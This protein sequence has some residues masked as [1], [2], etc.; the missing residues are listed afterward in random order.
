M[1][2]SFGVDPALEDVARLV[3]Q[4]GARRVL[5]AFARLA[6]A[7]NLV[8]QWRDFQRSFDLETLAVELHKLIEANDKGLAAMCLRDDAQATPQLAGDETVADELIH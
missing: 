6:N 4:H 2:M 1:A 3:R 5:E 7:G 8:A